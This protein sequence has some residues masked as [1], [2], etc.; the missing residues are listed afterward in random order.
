MTPFLEILRR[1]FSSSFKTVSQFLTWF[2]FTT[3]EPG[4]I[5]LKD[6]DFVL[7]SLLFPED[8]PE[9][10]IVRGS[11][12]CCNRPIGFGFCLCILNT[13]FEKLDHF[14]VP[15]LAFELLDVLDCIGVVIIRAFV[16]S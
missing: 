11:G 10:A 4:Y 5:A 8:D 3:V 13:P 14:V 9:V 12:R 15:A 2:R 7:V 1:Q 16:F 6:C